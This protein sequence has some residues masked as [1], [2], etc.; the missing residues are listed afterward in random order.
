LRVGLPGAVE[1]SCE[2]VE[3]Q[4]GEATDLALEVLVP[5]CGV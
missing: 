2:I 4:L 5:H 3:R 1:E